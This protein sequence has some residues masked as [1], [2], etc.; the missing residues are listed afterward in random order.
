MPLQTEI[1]EFTAAQTALARQCGLHLAS[2]ANLANQ[3]VDS[4]MALSDEKLTDWLN[5]KADVATN[6]FS[7]HGQLGGGI[8]SAA[9]AMKLP[10]VGVKVDIPAVDVRSV[11]EKLASAG[12]VLAFSNGAFSVTT[13]PITETEP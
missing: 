6:I 4:T 12:R 8:N 3:M 7:A 5:A 1:E 2:A 10:A 13:T 11:A 9:A